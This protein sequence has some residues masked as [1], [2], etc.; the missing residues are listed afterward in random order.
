MRMVL[1]KKIK[2][3]DKPVEISPVDSSVGQILTPHPI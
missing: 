3:K 2:D 1:K